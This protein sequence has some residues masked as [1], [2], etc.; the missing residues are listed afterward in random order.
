LKKSYEE[1]IQDKR[2]QLAIINL[3]HN[4]GYQEI[5]S[6]L[7][8]EVSLQQQELAQLSDPEEIIVLHTKWKT[9]Y[10][11]LSF[12]REQPQLFR[13]SYIETFGIEPEHDDLVN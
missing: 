3:E 11:I 12:L 13:E 10:S 2:L 6:K 8:E 4:P 9:G 1:V 5:I 7:A